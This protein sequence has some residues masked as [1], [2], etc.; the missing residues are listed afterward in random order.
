[1]SLSLI[2]LLDR[3]IRV[4]RLVGITRFGGCDPGRLI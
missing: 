2:A 4:R 1:M 3:I